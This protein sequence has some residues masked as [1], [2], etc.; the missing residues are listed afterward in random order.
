MD[1]PQQKGA[2]RMW[3]NATTRG[4]WTVSTGSVVAD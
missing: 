1:I 2:E 4:P 3:R